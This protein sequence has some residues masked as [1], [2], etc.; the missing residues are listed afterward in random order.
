MGIEDYC[1]RCG[2]PVREFSRKMAASTGNYYCV[3]CAEDIDRLY[4][5]KNSCSV[6]SRLLSRKENKFVMPSTVYNEYS[7]P[8]AKRLVCSGCYS[9]M[10]RGNMVR[11]L[12]SI[13]SM[14]SRLKSRLARR[15][16]ARAS[17]SA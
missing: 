6:C 15:F 3:R 8:L 2:T 14:R 10:A 16:V 4:L 5:A 13:G 11:S 7:R 17:A 12:P 9:R 1:G